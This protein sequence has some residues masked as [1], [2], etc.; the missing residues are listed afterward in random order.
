MKKL[1]TI[2]LICA[3][4]LFTLSLTDKKS[5]LTKNF[6]FGD[7]QIASINQLAFGPEGILFIGD[8]KNAA[9]YAIDTK[10]RVEKE[11]SE[12]I[13]V[14]DFDIKIAEALGHMV[15]NIAITDMAVNPISK[16][17]YFSVN[18]TD[19]TPVVLKLVGDG[20]E[21]ISL[22]ST[23][24]SKMPLENPVGLDEK[25]R[26]GRSIRNWAIAD[27]KYHKGNV[28]V[29]GLS[30]KEF[31][32]TFRSIPFPF[33][34]EQDYAS[35]EIWH[36]AH[37]RFE[38]YAPIKAFDII[39]IENKDYLMAGYTCTPLVLFPLKDLKNGTHLTG[40]TIAEL[41]AG[42]SPIDMIQYEK[43]GELLVYISNSNRPV[44]RLKYDDII[45]FKDSITHE[46]S[47]FG[48]SDGLDYDNLPFVNVLQMD[49][50]DQD[51]ALL[52]RRTSSGNL[53][54]TSRSKK[55]M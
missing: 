49:N 39:S 27:M 53:V 24:F 9:I 36:A 33:N 46:V 32:S 28:M 30:N 2:T 42:N 38:T 3:I 7:A 43:N 34:E 48:A 45:N 47:E 16:S 55:W 31:K 18:V 54:L 5:G 17:V 8:S 14:D 26:R 37:G 50:L 20:F 51:N 1:V 19:G 23:S 29:S 13:N 41:G 10:D 4:A 22:K 15:E 6:S 11:K 12:D 52:L 40:R 21:N 35:L 25:D 44:M